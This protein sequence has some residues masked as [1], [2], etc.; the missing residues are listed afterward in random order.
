MASFLGALDPGVVDEFAFRP[1]RPS[2]VTALASLFLHT[3]IA[4]LLGNLV[5]LAAV[6]PRVETVGGRGAFLTIYFVGGLAGVGA[7]ALMAQVTGWS[8]PLIGA[9]GAIAACAGYCAIRFM[10]RRVPLAP[11]VSVTVG[12][13]TLIWAGLQALGAFVSLGGATVTAFWTHLAGFFVGLALSLAFRAPEQADLQFGREVLGQMSERSPAA[14]LKAAERHLASHPTDP[15]ALRERATALGQMG[16]RGAEAEAWARY[17]EAVGTRL[18]PEAGARLAELGAF[19]LLP[20]YRRLR[21]AESWLAANPAEAQAFFE[22]LVDDPGAESVRSEALLG[23][24]RLVEG[25]DRERHLARL[26]A[27]YGLSDAARQAR[28]EGLLQ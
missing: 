18:E 19:G 16:E 26:Q 4:H 20:P 6:G 28:A 5:F 13:V 15:T 9:S 7:H 17:S 23:L 25:A 21:L 27:D 14:L 10:S 8:V 1:D 12:T 22:S 24:A 11:G 2:L 3:N